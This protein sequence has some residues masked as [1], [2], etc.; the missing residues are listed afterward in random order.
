MLKI[1]VLHPEI[2]AALAGAGHLAKVLISDGNFPHSTRPNPRARLVYANF[3]PGV[4]DAG[5]LLK[6]ICDLVPVEAAE[7]MA[8]ERSGAYAMHS[9][10]PIWT[11]FRQILAQ[12]SDFRGELEQLD[13]PQFVKA[14]GE[15]DV[16]LVIASA[17]QQIFA[18]ILI[19]IG[20][21]R[22]SE[23]GPGSL[24]LLQ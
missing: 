1:S 22:A 5:T 13:K 16:C 23:L 19:T 11:Q 21:G 4:V 15:Q 6:M 14:A 10:P 3:A 24:S 9:D 12:H 8:P 17:E 18:N 2:L 20:V 7:V